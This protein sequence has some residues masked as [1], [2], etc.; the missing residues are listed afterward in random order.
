M[1]V[2]PGGL[3]ER[4]RALRRTLLAARAG[5]SAADLARADAA[6]AE[7]A[8]AFFARQGATM[9]ACYASVGSEPPTDS[10][11][12]ALARAGTPVLLPVVQPAGRLDW[13]LAGPS[14]R[15]GAFGLREPDGP[16]LGGP[17]LARAEVALVPALAVDRAGHRLGRGGGYI[18]RAL[19]SARPALVLAVVYDEECFDE[20]PVAAHDASVDGWLTPNRGATLSE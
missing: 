15:T 7:T 20:L 18:D 1:A 5:R 8:A 14:W 10:L 6:L 16:L 12:A 17:A 3:T 9:V 4:K 13:A 11:L 2:H 19:H